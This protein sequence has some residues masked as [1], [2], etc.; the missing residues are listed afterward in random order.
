M[1][2]IA[3][4][5]TRDYCI[6]LTDFY[7]YDLYCETFARKMKDENKGENSHIHEEISL[8]IVFFGASNR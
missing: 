8:N 6:P 4:W 2:N 7:N 3:C 5:C 1:S